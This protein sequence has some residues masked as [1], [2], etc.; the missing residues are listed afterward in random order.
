MRSILIL[1]S[2]MTISAWLPAQV[3]D[4]SKNIFIYLEGNSQDYIYHA[5]KLRTRFYDDRGLFE[6]WLPLDQ[7]S[8]QGL[9]DTKMAEMVLKDSEEFIFKLSFIIEEASN[10]K[11]FKEPENFVVEGKLQIAG[12]QKEVP[13]HI[14]LMSS[15]GTLFYKM[16]FT[17]KIEQ[18]PMPYQEVLTGQVVFVIK[19]SKWSDFFN[20]Y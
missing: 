12:E 17:T 16:S 6:F 14:T 11:N 3:L 9:S 20:N 10:L 15:S 19:Q 1:I 4:P 13:V 7:I 8:A 5:E 18:I 2:L